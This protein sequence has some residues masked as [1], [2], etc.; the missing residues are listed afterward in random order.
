MLNTETYLNRPNSY[1]M[2]VLMNAYKITRERYRK[3]LG[4]SLGYLNN[5][6]HR[7]S[8][9]IRDMYILMYLIYFDDSDKREALSGYLK[10]TGDWE[11]I[12]A[13]RVSEN[14]GGESK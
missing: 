12:E 14:S 8:F 4:V 10:L 11:R 1:L 6:F 3:Y 5:K 9:S 7:S 2:A 13:L